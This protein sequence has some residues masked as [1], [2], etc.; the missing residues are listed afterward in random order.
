MDRYVV[1]KH[2]CCNSHVGLI[3][4]SNEVECHAFDGKLIGQCGDCGGLF[5]L[6]TIRPMVYVVHAR[7]VTW[8][9]VWLKKLPKLPPEETDI[10]APSRL[11]VI[12]PAQGEPTKC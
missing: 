8:P 9:L 11:S 2:P 1:V 5:D 6:R 4:E 10:D 12:T 3:V 7:M